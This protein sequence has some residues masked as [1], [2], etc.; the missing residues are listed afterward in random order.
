MK[1]IM[2]VL[3]TMSKSRLDLVIKESPKPSGEEKSLQ[4][5]AKSP[6]ILQTECFQ[7]SSICTYEQ[8]SHQ[9]HHPQL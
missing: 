8:I 3:I 2:L 5:K 1:A 4:Y 9:E 6:S 7:E